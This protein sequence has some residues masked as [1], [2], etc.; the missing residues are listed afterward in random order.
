[1]QTREKFGSQAKKMLK[2]MIDLKDFNAYKVV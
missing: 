2:I 1:M